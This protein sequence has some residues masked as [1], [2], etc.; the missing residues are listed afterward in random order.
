[1][2]C[3]ACGSAWGVHQPGAARAPR[4]SRLVPPLR[5]S[6]AALLR[7]P[8]EG[9][10]ARLHGGRPPGPGARAG[11][12][13]R[14]T[15][16]LRPRRNRVGARGAAHARD[17][18]QPRDRHGAPAAS[19]ARRRERGAGRLHARP[20]LLGRPNVRNASW[21]RQQR[22]A[23]AR[24]SRRSGRSGVDA[25]ASPQYADPTPG[26]SPSWMTQSRTRTP[27]A[28]CS[29]SWRACRTGG[30]TSCTR[31]AAAAA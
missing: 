1:M 26:A 27:S 16:G 23:Q 17:R 2:A 6:E 29:K 8:G 28:R 20:H 24:T 13:R 11:P 22:C 18:R 3:T 7:S 9:S 10:P 21:P 5:R 31:L 12:P 19:A 25:T 4:V 15:R 30:F 14:A